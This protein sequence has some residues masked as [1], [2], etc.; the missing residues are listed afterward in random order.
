M[1]TTSDPFNLQRF[2]NAQ[3]SV[4]DDVCAE[5]RQGEKTS[6]WMWFIFPQIHGLGSSPMAQKFAIGSV[7]EARAYLHHPVLGPRL[8]ECTRLVNN[9]QGRSLHQI[10]GS[11]DDMKFRSCMTLFSNV[12][13]GTSEFSEALAKYCGCVPDPRTLEMLR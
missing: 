6:H 9:V 1:A 3:E 5:L 11:P 8:R 2:V 10:F 7:D 13:P 12:A 4:F